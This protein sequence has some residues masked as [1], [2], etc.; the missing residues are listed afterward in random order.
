[1]LCYQLGLV[2]WGRVVLKN[3]LR[4]AVR[5]FSGDSPFYYLFSIIPSINS[6][7]LVP[8]EGMMNIKNYLT[9]TERK[10][11]KESANLHPQAIFRHNSAPRHKAKLITQYL[12]KIKMEVLERFGNSPDL[13]PIENLW[14]IVKNRLKKQY[15]TT[16]MKLIQSVLHK[17]FHDDEMKNNCKKLVV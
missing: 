15:C 5:R 9:K 12:S 3:G 4:M 10:G 11:C 17:C 2:T 1:M 6:R 16:K 8:I 14:S 7:A 13:K